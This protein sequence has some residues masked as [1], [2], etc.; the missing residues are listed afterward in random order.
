MK[1]H[2]LSRLEK[3]ET[4]FYEPEE[5]KKSFRFLSVQLKG[6]LSCNSG[7]PLLAAWFNSYPAK[8]IKSRDNILI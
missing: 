1:Q 7:W 4:D 5:H 6:S 8:F 3:I 2:G